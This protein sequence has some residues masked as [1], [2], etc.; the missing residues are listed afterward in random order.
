MTKHAAAKRKHP[1]PPGPKGKFLLGHFREVVH[2]SNRFLE[3]CSR[4]YGDVV[5]LRVFHVPVCLLANPADIESVLSKNSANFLKA[6]DYRAMKAVLGEGLLTSEGS[7]WQ[8][9]R[10][11]MQPAFRHE[12]ITTY[13]ET[14]VSATSRMLDTWRN[15]ETRDVHAEFMAVTLE[16]VT[17]VLFGSVVPGDA[18]T[19][20]KSLTIMMEDFNRQGALAFLLPESVP[21][22]TFFRLKRAI[23]TV[24]AMIYKL[25]D[26]RRTDRRAARNRNGAPSGHDLL[27]TLLSAQDEA[28]SEMTSE[29]VRDEVMTLFLAG[30]ETTANALSWTWYLLAQHPEVAKKLAAEIDSVLEGR[31][32]TAA[33]AA[34]PS[35]HGKSDQGINARVSP[36]LGD[37]AAV[38]QTVRSGRVPLSRENKRRDLAVD[39]APRSAILDRSGSFRSGALVAERRAIPRA[40]A[41]RVFS[42]WRRAQSLHRRGLR[43]DGS[44]S[45]ARHR[46]AALRDETRAAPKGADAT[47]RDLAAAPRD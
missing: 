13:A 22:P 38:D 28:G 19:V 30:H 37:R 26:A 47:Q 39:S 7:F 3:R 41:L 45:A 29:Q 34:S 27:E 4:E 42:F 9:Q 32:P 16:I 12:N 31:V 8:K 6:R 20:A 10:K 46:G 1:R 21:I 17:K 18:A 25:I 40:S 15:G 5:R 14:M 43:D 44:D 2:S 33:D 36:G 11:L 35:V 23:E 24:D